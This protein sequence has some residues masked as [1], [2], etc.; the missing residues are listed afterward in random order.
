[1]AQAIAAKPPTRQPR[2]L[3]QL[4]W[5]AGA[6][7]G[8]L[9]TLRLAASVSRWAPWRAACTQLPRLAMVKLNGIETSAGAGSGSR[10]PVRALWLSGADLRQLRRRDADHAVRRLRG[11]SRLAGAD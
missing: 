1:M 3:H 6:V 2:Y 8:L 4:G 5:R 10:K 11:P 9:C 7:A